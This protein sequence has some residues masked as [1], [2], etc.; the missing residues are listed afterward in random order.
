MCDGV[1]AKAG[2]RTSNHHQGLVAPSVVGAP[3]EHTQRRHEDEESRI[4]FV[5]DQPEGYED[6][7]WVSDET[8]C[9]ARQIIAPLAI[10]L[11]DV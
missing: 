7:S 11:S 5:R 10:S 6:L 8:G 1:V 4:G 9:S 2:A 3:T